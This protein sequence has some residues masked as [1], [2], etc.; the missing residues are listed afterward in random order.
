MDLIR[1]A[2]YD[3][4][5]TLP[6]VTKKVLSVLTDWQKE[7]TKLPPATPLVDNTNHEESER[8]GLPTLT[9]AD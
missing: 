6:A 7:L 2:M 1:T 5:A 8:H 3:T 4:D 9:L